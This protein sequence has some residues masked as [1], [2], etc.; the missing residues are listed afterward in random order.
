MGSP[1]KNK[2]AAEAKAKADFSREVESRRGWYGLKTNESL[3]AACGMTKST[4]RNRVMDPDN[5]TVAELRSMV[6]RLRLN[7]TIVACFVGYDVKAVNKALKQLSE[8][9][10]QAPLGN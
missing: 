3:G 1:T 7:L 4:M 8:G 5:L 10:V 9:S 6:Q 2:L